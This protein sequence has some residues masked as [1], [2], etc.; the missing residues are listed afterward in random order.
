MLRDEQRRFGD[1]LVRGRTVMSRRTG[2]G[3]PTEEELRYLH[4]THGLPRELVTG[5]LSGDGIRLE[6]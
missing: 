1:L 2:S 6:R 4:E 3:L 5:L